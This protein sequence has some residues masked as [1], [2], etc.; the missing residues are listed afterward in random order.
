MAFT[1]SDGT[2]LRVGVAKSAHKN[3]NFEIS[4]YEYPT[5]V[6]GSLVVLKEP[7]KREHSLVEHIGF[8]IQGDAMN[9]PPINEFEL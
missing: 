1:S 8:E 6:F 3:F 5:C 2:S 9:S 7:G 4:P